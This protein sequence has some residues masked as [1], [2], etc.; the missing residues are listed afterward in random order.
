MVMKMVFGFYNSMVFD[1]LFLPNLIPILTMRKNKAKQR[2]TKPVE[3][4][5]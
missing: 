3:N 5:E 4:E 1:L 2:Q